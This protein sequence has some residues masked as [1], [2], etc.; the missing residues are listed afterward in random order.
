M[1]KLKLPYIFLKKL[2]ISNLTVFSSLS[3]LLY[4]KEIK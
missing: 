1:I 3:L 4:I 2:L